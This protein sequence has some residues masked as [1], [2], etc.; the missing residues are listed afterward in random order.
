MAPAEAE[1]MIRCNWLTCL[2]KCQL[3]WAPSVFEDAIEK[4]L[5]TP[6]SLWEGD[7]PF[8]GEE[9]LCPAYNLANEFELRKW[10]EGRRPWHLARFWAKWQ[11]L[12]RAF[13]I[14][15][16]KEVDHDKPDNSQG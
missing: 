4:R 8:K 5:G 14:G 13:P 10:G 9:F 6:I 3:H 2:S 15:E 11:A 12:R 7:C 16:T 1:K